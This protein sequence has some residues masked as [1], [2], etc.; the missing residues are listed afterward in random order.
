M[1][2]ETIKKNR[3]TWI[4]FLREPGRK[5]IRGKLESMNDFEQRCCIGHGCYVLGMDRQKLARGVTYD[6]EVNVAPASFI[7]AVGLWDSIG[8]IENTSEW[9]VS[10]SLARL[11]DEYGR[12]PQ[13]IG[14]YLAEVIEGGVDTPFKPLD[15][16]S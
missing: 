10:Q 8:V 4:D 5:K 14:E 1:D 13:E 3:Q 15:D 2:R 6:G 12:S 11:N 16:Y 7:E 9:A